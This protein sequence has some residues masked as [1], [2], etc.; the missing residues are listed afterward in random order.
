MTANNNVLPVDDDSNVLHSLKRQLRDKFT[1]KT[2]GS[3]EQALEKVKGIIPFSVIVSD[4]RMPGMG[5][6]QFLAK[7]AK[8]CPDRTRVSLIGNTDLY[9]AIRAFNEGNIFRFLTKPCHPEELIG[10]ISQGIEK[11]Q[12]TTSEKELLGKT[13]RGSIN[14]L[15]ELQSVISPDVF[16]LSNKI[17]RLSVNIASQ[18]GICD[19]SQIETATMLSQI[20]YATLPENTVR[21]W[22]PA[23]ISTRKKRG[24][25][26]RTLK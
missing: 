24:S 9:I 18:M 6:I 1:V 11:Y 4:L 25:Y 12:L 17:K 20:G 13:L 22:N 23:K 3:P 21:K 19:Y 7:E 16:G 14:M 26:P 2:T 8:E 10:T 15:M 5:G